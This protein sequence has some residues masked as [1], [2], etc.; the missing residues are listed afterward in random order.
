MSD[1][2][3]ESGGLSRSENE[4]ARA[5]SGQV[6]ASQSSSSGLRTPRDIMNQR[7]AREARR[8][9]EA[10]AAASSETQERTQEEE[11]RR[12]AERRATAA[13]VTGS[14]HP[15]DSGYRSAGVLRGER[16]KPPFSATSPQSATVA[17]FT[18]EL[19]I[20]PD[21]QADP[22]Y[23]TPR[24]GGSSG[25]NPRG[26]GNE[27]QQRVSQQPRMPESPVGQHQPKSAA[28]PSAPSQT[29]R[30]GNVPP[31]IIPPG[32]ENTQA[33][34]VSSFPHAFERWETLS[35]HWE[36]LT[37][38][39]IRRL[40]QN[41][42]EIR[43][44][45]S[46]SQMSRHITDLS[47][48]G[49]NLF[50]AVVELQRLRA[51]SERKFQRW[52][53]ETRSQQERDQDEI[54]RLQEELESDRQHKNRASNVNLERRISELTGSYLEVD[55]RNAEL[56]RELQISKDEARR[57]WEELGR[58]EH[59]ER[60]RQLALREGHPIYI[61]GVQVQPMQ[62]ALSRGPSTREGPYQSSIGPEHEYENYM[63]QQPSP[64]DTD[65]FTATQAST[66]PQRPYTVGAYQSWT[67]AAE[68]P[69]V[70][71]TTGGGD[72][73]SPNFP[74]TR[75]RP[76]QTQSV[77]SPISATAPMV[78]RFYQPPSTHV[79]H[80]ETSAAASR[81][82]VPR[83]DQ[84]SEEEPWGTDEYGYAQS[85]PYSHS[86]PQDRTPGSA[87]R[88]MRQSS[89]IEDS[90]EEEGA[91][92]VRMQQHENPRD[93]AAQAASESSGPGISGAIGPQTS[94]EGMP[95]PTEYEDGGFGSLP[96]RL[97]PWEPQPQFQR[98][99]RLSDVVEED[100]DGRNP[101]SGRRA[102]A[103]EM[104]GVSRRA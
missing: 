4:S 22:Q 46:L 95:D 97:P 72:P 47:A 23:S 5:T 18:K 89:R 70:P 102:R 45:I 62:D 50:H 30:G 74:S 68:Q 91:D 13:G 10:E 14:G 37:S 15:R 55:R 33:R 66:R 98:S 77:V 41:A 8:R 42:E 87:T 48:A 9:A 6:P 96:E 73:V 101:P 103:I 32:T 21:Q 81:P 83:D 16:S 93:Q 54:A 64:T 94:H 56:R 39:W 19:P 76:A 29:S 27:E 1:L 17:T 99:A 85:D 82:P 43:K 36:G 90:N 2:G 31:I 58:R 71:G 92:D 65:P 25:S 63:P 12:N 60:D 51:S 61:G 34:T 38:Y 67:P 7:Q 104:T 49:A 28:T 20:L 75:S 11:L 26:S 78:S 53:F 52:F 57:A 84:P 80:S 59:E 44:D 86:S 24:V 100:D 79:S 88:G 40:E 69:I 35:S 3:R